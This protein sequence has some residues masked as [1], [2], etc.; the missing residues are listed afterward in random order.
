MKVS[1]L[2]TLTHL[3][4][5]CSRALP[6]AEL[7]IRGRTPAVREGPASRLS[8]RCNLCCFCVAS[9][10]ARVLFEVWPGMVVARGSGGGGRRCE[11]P[12]APPCCSTRRDPGTS[13]SASSSAVGH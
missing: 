8:S 5:A 9:H 11:G 6:D 7:D 12:G 10:C 13:L 3:H 1:R 4:M 2:V